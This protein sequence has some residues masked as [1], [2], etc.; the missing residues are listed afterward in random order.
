MDAPDKFVTWDAISN[1]ASCLSLFANPPA[2]LT[3]PSQLLPGI[4]TI[5]HQKDYIKDSKTDNLELEY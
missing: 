5:G 1:D 2:S 4:C 3:L